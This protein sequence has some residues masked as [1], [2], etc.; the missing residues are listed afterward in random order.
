MQYN[1]KVVFSLQGRYRGKVCY[2][3]VINETTYVDEEHTN[4]TDN[5]GDTAIKIITRDNKV[6]FSNSVED[7]FNLKW[8]EIDNI[9]YYEA[10]DSLIEPDSAKIIYNVSQDNKIGI[11]K[12]KNDA[13]N[14]PALVSTENTSRLPYVLLRNGKSPYENFRNIPYISCSEPKFFSGEDEKKSVRVFNGDSYVSPMKYV[15]T[16]FKEQCQLL[17]RHNGDTKKF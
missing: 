1:K 7:N 6:A 5:D 2:R 8:E 16:H 12:L 14:K 17:E 11:L 3:N 9:S 4:D 15:N 13:P 10:Y